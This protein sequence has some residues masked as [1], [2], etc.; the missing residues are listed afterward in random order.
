MQQARA[1]R[2]IVQL[3]HIPATLNTIP[4]PCR[5]PLG[6]MCISGLSVIFGSSEVAT[7]NS[8]IIQHEQALAIPLLRWAG[9]RKETVYAKFNLYSVLKSCCN[10]Q[11]LLGCVLVR[12]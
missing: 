9:Q 2:Q 12:G 6:P 4:M 8:V 3:L 7:S 5:G 10:I 1:Q 11:Q